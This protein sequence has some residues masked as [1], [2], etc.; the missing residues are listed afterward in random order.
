MLVIQFMHE[1]MNLVN[2]LKKR[3]GSLDVSL[4]DGLIHR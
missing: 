2:S 1:T 4:E 3:K